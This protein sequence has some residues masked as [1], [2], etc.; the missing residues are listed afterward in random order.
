M[1]RNIDADKLLEKQFFSLDDDGYG[2]MVVSVT[3]IISAPTMEG[4]KGEWRKTY[5]CSG[6]WL[7]GYEC[8]QCKADNPRASYYC[9]N[10]GADMRGD[11][12]GK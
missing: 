10:C 3:D 4:K 11:G 2:M 8:S 5:T 12:D 9:P 6:E 1:A 7:W